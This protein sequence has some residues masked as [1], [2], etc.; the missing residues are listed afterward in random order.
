MVMKTLHDENE[1][2]DKL[3]IDDNI[4]SGLF[5]HLQEDVELTEHLFEKLD[6]K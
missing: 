4:K 6:E 1:T 5:P 3:R 2:I